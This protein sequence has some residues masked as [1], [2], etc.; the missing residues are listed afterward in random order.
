MLCYLN[1]PVT[2]VEMLR[3]LVPEAMPRHL[4]V[5]ISKASTLSRQNSCKG[6]GWTPTLDNEPQFG[7]ASF[8]AE[9]DAYTVDLSVSTY[10]VKRPIS[11]PGSLLRRSASGN[12]VASKE[13]CS[14]TALRSGT[15]GF[16][17]ETRASAASKGTSRRCAV[18]LAA[19]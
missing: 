14:E 5:E 10:L 17:D 6:L 12:Q 13:R 3:N 4:R 8:Q 11:F 7:S 15:V 19:R 9:W 18:D 1:L 16:S 2:R